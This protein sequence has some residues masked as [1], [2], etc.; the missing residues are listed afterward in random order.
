LCKISD[1][2]EDEF[3]SVNVVVGADE[4]TYVTGSLPIFGYSTIGEPNTMFN[5]IPVK[6]AH[7]DRHR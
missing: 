5:P 7:A 6:G 4:E 3:W 1:A 2:A